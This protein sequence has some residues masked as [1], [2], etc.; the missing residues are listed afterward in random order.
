MRNFIHREN[1]QQQ[2]VSVA[3]FQNDQVLLIKRRDIPVFVLPGGG[4]EPGETPE[5]AACRE[6]LEETGYEV[7][8]VRKVAEYTPVNSLTQLTHFFECAILS[9]TPTKGAETKEIAFFPLNSLPKFL[10]P[11][12]PGWISDAAAKHPYLI[13]KPVEGASYAALLK[14]LILHPILV[15]R[16]LLTKIGIHINS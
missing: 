13:R 9:G 2:A 6:A 8:I 7:T 5:D 12:Y 16:F 4:I 15:F 11:P 10:V 1:A 14:N 3:I